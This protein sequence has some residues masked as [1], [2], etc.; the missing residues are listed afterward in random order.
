MIK[1]KTLNQ[2]IYRYEIINGA[3][4]I[5]NA[6]SLNATIS[7]PC[8]IDGCTVKVLD[9]VFKA[10]TA[11]VLNKNIEGLSPQTQLLAPKITL[12]EGLKTINPWLLKNWGQAICVLPSSVTN[13]ASVLNS[14]TWSAYS[15]ENSVHYVF[16]RRQLFSVNKDGKWEISAWNPTTMVALKKYQLDTPLLSVRHRAPRN[17]DETSLKADA[18]L[19]REHLKF[20]ARQFSHRQFQKDVYQANIE[21][22]TLTALTLNHRYLNYLA[23]EANFAYFQLDDETYDE[24]DRLV[25]QATSELDLLRLVYDFVK[26]DTVY[27]KSAKQANTSLA[28]VV[29]NKRGICQHFA[30]FF[31]VVAS[32]CGFVV[33]LISAEQKTPCPN[34]HMFICVYLKSIE[35]YLYLDSTS[36]YRFEEDCAEFILNIVNTDAA[37]LLVNFTNFRV[38]MLAWPPGT[39][40]F[41]HFRLNLVGLRELGYLSYW[42][43]NPQPALSD[44][45]NTIYSLL[46]A[47]AD[48]KTV[49]QGVTGHAESFGKQGVYYQLKTDGAKT[50]QVVRTVSVHGVPDYLKK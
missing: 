40:Y 32:Y 8:D 42:D 22:K 30:E 36:P 48:E 3:A 20:N 19:L 2:V 11:I 49:Y 29:K 10:E 18:K 50:H 6:V 9:G 44:R 38:L 17:F 47:P 28:Y 46:V 34:Y 24:L 5:K 16:W 25:A 13:V 26:K 35:D 1:T 45:M 15:P 4:T 7:F 31:A 33:R 21:K 41:S 14:L 12:V 23:E 39:N 27:D 37:Y 43:D